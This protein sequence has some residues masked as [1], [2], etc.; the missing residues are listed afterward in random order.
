MLA[1]SSGRLGPAGV[2]DLAATAEVARGMGF[3][4]VHAARPPKDAETARPV[5]DRLG[6]ALD[7]VATAPLASVVE[8]PDVLARAA[9]A[10][11]ALRER[12]VVLDA[13]DLAAGS[14]ETPAVA[15]ETLARALHGQTATWSGLSIAVRAAA[16]GDRLLGLAETEWLL[17]ALKGKPVG[18]WLDPA[19]ATTLLRAKR[20]GTALDWAERL[21]AR[22]MGV[23]VHGLGASGKGHALPEDD[24]ADWGTLRGL[25]SA[26]VP[27]VLDVG[28]A[29]EASDVSDA[30]RHFEEDLHW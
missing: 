15:V 18:L 29:V 13:G 17:D 20:P 1:L 7:G 30:R 22:T 6:L 24:G 19:R 3:S 26:R 21:G 9:R 8:L 14:R 12:L 27:R 4:R 16:R 28:A 5:L 10:A 2:R 25:L 11:A 23:A